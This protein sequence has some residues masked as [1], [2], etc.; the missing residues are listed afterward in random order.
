MWTAGL[1][2]G[3]LGTRL[4][5]PGSI[6]V[7]QQITFTQPVYFGGTI[8]ARAEVLE[9]LVERRRVRLSTVCVNQRGEEVLVGE[10]LLSPPKSD[11]PVH[12]VV[13]ARSRPGIRQRAI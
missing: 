2:S 1:M 7:S 9:R 13:P 5:G 11:A 6:Y 10:A 3:V 8:T 4:P 12:A